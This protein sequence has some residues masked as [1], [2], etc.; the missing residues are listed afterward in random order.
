MPGCL[1]LEA[2][3]FL[4][5]YNWRSDQDIDQN[6]CLEGTTIPAFPFVAHPS[7]P[8]VALVVN[9]WVHRNQESTF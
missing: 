6:G 3:P 2:T 7:G 5:G 8:A 9:K 1:Q 4:P